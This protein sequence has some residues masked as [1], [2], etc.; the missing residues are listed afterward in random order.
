MPFTLSVLKAFV[1]RE[2]LQF[3]EGAVQINPH[4]EWDDVP[5]DRGFY[6]LTEAREACAGEKM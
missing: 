5:I 6:A 3:L 1:D 2:F 4:S